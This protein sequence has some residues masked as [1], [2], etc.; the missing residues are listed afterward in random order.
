MI[1]TVA[2]VAPPSSDDG[3]TI[4]LWM[5]AP[6]PRDT[7]RLR[8][9]IESSSQVFGQAGGVGVALLGGPLAGVVAGAAMGEAFSRVATEFYDRVAATRHR[10]RGGKALEVALAR[11]GERVKDGDQPRQDG[12]FDRGPDGR[13]HADEV[14]EGTL[15]TAANA[16]EERK[17]AP[18]GRLYANVAFD[19]TISPRWANFLLRLADRLT[20]TQL[21][22]LAFVAEANRPGRYEN[23]VVSLEALASE[24]R[25]PPDQTLY[26]ELDDLS[27]SQLIGLRQNS[28]PPI[29]PLA[30]MEAWRWTP[31][32][33]NRA[34]LMPNA[35][36]LH[37][38][39]ELDQLPREEL[40]AVLSGLR[41]DRD[42]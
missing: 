16:W 10:A 36:T 35:R 30:T 29:P 11:V 28:G 1:P 20:Y 7:D 27:T 12:F 32:I 6:S 25:V 34:D 8:D 19:P 37:D 26:A 4:G 22:L 40:D 33:L 15:F 3:S 21:V 24:V 23:A 18:L 31:S 2:R 42:P 14:L 13:A 39:M 38:L 41:G 5:D 9:L 17:V